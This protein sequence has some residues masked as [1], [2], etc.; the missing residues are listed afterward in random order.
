MNTSQY[1]GVGDDLCGEGV[2]EV[3]EDGGVGGGA[4]EGLR[5]DGLGD[6]EGV[7]RGALG[8]DRLDL[9]APLHVAPSLPPRPDQQGA[10]GGR[11]ALLH[12][13]GGGD[14]PDAPLRVEG[15]VGLGVGCMNSLSLGGEMFVVYLAGQV[16]SKV[17]MLY[18]NIDFDI[19]FIRNHLLTC[20]QA[21]FK[22]LRREERDAT[23]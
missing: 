13:G 5:Q 12:G 17:S 3:S 22:K 8:D 10:E 2:A 20:T 23:P 15:H 19:N 1:G 7:A 21:I 14:G 16:L 11:G 9:D 18:C 4:G 6:P